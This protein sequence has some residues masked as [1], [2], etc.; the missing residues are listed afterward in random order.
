MEE[1]MFQITISHGKNGTS[2]DYI[3]TCE[4]D[5]KKIV[6]DKANEVLKRERE[7]DQMGFRKVFGNTYKA[8]KTL[9]VKEYSNITKKAIR[10]GIV[11]KLKLLYSQTNFRG[12]K[13]RT[14]WYEPESV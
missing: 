3:K 2:C 5:F 8:P 13:V 1:K 7:N 4:K 12:M 11:F 9:N 14:E 6:A 10:G